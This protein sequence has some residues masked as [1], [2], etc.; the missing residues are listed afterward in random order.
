MQHSQTQIPFQ[1]VSVKLNLVDAS[2]HPSETPDWL[3][4]CYE[5]C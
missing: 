5:F 1:T 2:E 3:P 4:D